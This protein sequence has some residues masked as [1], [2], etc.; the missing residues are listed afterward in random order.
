[1]SLENYSTEQ[2]EKV[3]KGAPSFANY[4]MHDKNL[5]GEIGF[6]SERF[7]IG[8]HNKA[9]SFK[10]S[11]IRAYLDQKSNSH[12]IASDCISTS[13]S[14]ESVESSVSDEKQSVIE[15]VDFISFDDFRDLDKREVNKKI[16]A[17][18]GFECDDSWEY[19]QNAMKDGVNSP[20][21][22][23][24]TL[25]RKGA[26]RFTSIGWNPYQC[27]DAAFGLM[28]DMNLTV[29]FNGLDRSDARLAVVY[30]AYQQLDKD[31]DHE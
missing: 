30:A 5:H 22:A 16:A 18:L 13:Q 12:E 25:A 1:M 28:V 3:L 29:S 31:A 2:L 10:L 6:Y 9:T 23:N 24:L 14:K 17:H 8:H 26:D 11:D 7:V 4:Y 19:N 27:G 21:Y 15:C 20:H